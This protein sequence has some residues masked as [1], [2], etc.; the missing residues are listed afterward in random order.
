[1][2]G[3]CPRRERVVRIRW[4]RLVTNGETCQRCSSTE[5]ELNKALEILKLLLPLSIRFE[6]EKVEIPYE[7]FKKDP[8]KSNQIFIND[9]PIEEYLGA[10]VGKSGCCNV[11]ESYEC[12]NLEI[13]NEVYEAIPA[14]LIV[15]AVIAALG[16]CC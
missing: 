12:R 5:K 3:C 10:K 8:L 16:S 9:R 6:V 14:N 15:E 4:Q 11:C 13:D 7:E 2:A 1:M